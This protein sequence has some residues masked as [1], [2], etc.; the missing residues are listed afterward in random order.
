MVEVWTEIGAAR[1]FGWSG[2]SVLSS[3]AILGFDWADSDSVSAQLQPVEPTCLDLELA[4]SY[5]H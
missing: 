1:Y 5:Y 3:V 4:D 2:Y